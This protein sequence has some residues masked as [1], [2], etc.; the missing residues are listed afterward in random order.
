MLPEAARHELEQAAHE[1]GIDLQP[2]QIEQLLG[3]LAL[4]GRW[5]KVYNLT[6]IR[7]PGEMLRQHLID[8]LAAIPPLRHRLQQRDKTSAA[9]VLDVGS[10]A[11][12]PGLT[13]AIAM[14]ETEVVCVDSVGKKAGFIRQAIAELGVGQARA[15]HAR[16]EDLKP[17]GADIITSRAFASLADFIRLTRSH[18]APRGAWMALKGRHPDPEIAALPD[19]IEVFH[20]EQLHPPGLAGERCL[21]WMRSRAS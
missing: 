3:H 4:L 13:I 9:K 6:A 2:K 1:L 17:I 12:F 5:G 16:I 20:V 18:L 11:G 8:S 15:E 10:G 14:P 7:E 19:E 21:V